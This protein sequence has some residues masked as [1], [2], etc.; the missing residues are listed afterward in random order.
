M[1]STKKVLFFKKVAVVLSIL[2]TMI[3]Y[4]FFVY[5]LH[6]E[7]KHIRNE[8]IMNARDIARQS[9]YI[10]LWAFNQ[11]AK[12][13]A[14][15]AKLELKTDFSL[16]NLIY[17]MSAERGAKTVIE[18]NYLQD[19]LVN[20]NEKIKNTIKKMQRTKQDQ[21]VLYT[22]ENQKE[23]FYIK[24]LLNDGS[25]SKCH[26]HDDKEKGDLLGNVN[27]KM[28][29][30]TFKDYKADSYFFIIAMY[31]STWFFGLGVIW[32]IRYKNKLF[33]EKSVRSYE[34]SIYALV[35]MMERRD[36]YT[37]GHSKRVANYASMIA[38][39]YGCSDDDVDKI[40]RAGML[41]DIGKVEIPDALLLKP[42]K[43]DND[44]YELIKTHSKFGYELLSRE[45]FIELSSIVLHH[46]ERYDGNGYPYGLKKDEIP[47]LSQIICVADAFDAMTTNRAYRESYSVQK[48]LEILREES[49]K[50]FNP[51]I[52]RVALKA[53]K[54]VQSP[55]DTTQMPRNPLEEMRFSYYFKDQLTNCYNS[56]YLKF[57]LT[58]KQAH[59]KIC[60][61]HVNC[62]NFTN[63]N[64]KY[65]W[66]N[67]NLLLKNIAYSLK[68]RYKDSILIR[69]FGDNFFLITLGEHLEI[70]ENILDPILEGKNM[71]V[72]YR[73]M[74]LS[75]KNIRTVEDLEDKIL[76]N[77]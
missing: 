15:Q 57:L 14:K 22:A 63:Y 35:D 53:L 23:I 50:Q 55:E 3:T 59:S 5:Q 43:L 10:I 8:V 25:C 30:P 51:T 73:H 67:G 16:R 52:V 6:T 12:H 37:A 74:D 46:H 18:G 49:G 19:D 28:S 32:F 20:L 71:D 21:F 62:K 75:G 29:I 76:Q 70:D 48:A 1:P 47:L 68:D 27:L 42:D 44:E 34:E 66:H 13:K 11:K 31:L 36:S 41:H 61:Y 7:Q 24:P 4:I 2:W 33:Y 54:N 39:A 64:K 58:H 69:T 72:V 56:S 38:D 40:Y 77:N 45:P 65:G 26:V 60:V 17:K 9:E